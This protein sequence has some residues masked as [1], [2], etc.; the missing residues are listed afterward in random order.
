M[1]T[2][3][4]WQLL[5]TSWWKLLAGLLIGAILTVPVLALAPKE[6]T[7]TARVLVQSSPSDDTRAADQQAYIDS[8][9][10]T[11]IALAQ[12]DASLEKIAKDSGD[13]VD[14]QDVRDGIT[15][16]AD[17]DSAVITITGTGDGPRSASRLTES[18]AENFVDATPEASGTESTKVKILEKASSATLPSSPD[19]LIVGPALMILG[20]LVAFLL[21]LL[22]PGGRR[23]PR[24]ARELAYL[25]DAPALGV[26]EPHGARLHRDASRRGLPTTATGT[27][28]R[29]RRLGDPVIALVGV[30]SVDEQ[31]FA[32][33]ERAVSA[34]EDGA[35]AEVHRLAL[36]D[37]L[38]ELP[39][40]AG[41]VLVVSAACSVRTLQHAARF[42]RG[43]GVQV[44]GV[45]VAPADGA[46][47]RAQG[48]G[49]QEREGI[50]A[51]EVAAPDA[52]STASAA[53]TSRTSDDDQ[54]R[55]SISVHS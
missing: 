48:R 51:D 30:G 52:R 37:E 53:D 36:A 10:P 41:A 13:G 54:V 6:Y 8:M 47:G 33:L 50:A 23:R 21:A 29:I 31:R 22:S 2:E 11:F 42:A 24:S 32:D 12:S 34:S 46:H 49:P 35:D 15:Y 39:A 14:V 19:P 5:A 3:R 55:G 25:T 26:L 20:L 1:S 7:S 17:T 28:G 27:A 38:S 45:V 44:R 4:L 18:A 40:E 16:E 43:H 9:L